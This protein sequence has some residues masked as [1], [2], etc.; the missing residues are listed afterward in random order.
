[1]LSNS[2][3]IN[4]IYEQNI[5]LFNKVNYKYNDISNSKYTLYCYIYLLN[6]N[7]FSDGT[8][9]VLKEYSKPVNGATDL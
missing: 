3:C 1:M 5:I 4:I 6:N 8:Y 7:K 9:F 2:F